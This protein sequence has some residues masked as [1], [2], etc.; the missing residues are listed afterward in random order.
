MSDVDQV[1]NDL[2]LFRR[3]YLDLLD[4]VSNAAER[5]QH[6]FGPN[7]VSDVYIRP[8]L[9]DGPFKSIEKI[10]RKL[11]E[12]GLEGPGA[13]L[14]LND[15]IG[16]TIVVQYPDQREVA[17]AELRAQL[18]KDIVVGEAEVH[19]NKRGYYAHHAI[20]SRLY[21]IHT[22]R[23]EVQVKTMLHNAWAQKMHDLTYKP[24]GSL[25]TRLEK[26]MIAGANMIESAEQQSQTIR[27]MIL[28]SW[29]VERDARRQAC[30]YVFEE[31]LRYNSDLWK[32]I[33][34]QTEVQMLHGDI[35][36]A[37]TWL[38]KEEPGS[39]RLTELLER[40]NACGKR[41]A[42][43]GWLFAGRLASIRPDENLVSSCILLTDRWLKALP[44][45]VRKGDIRSSEISAIPLMF[46]IMNNFDDAIR[47]ADRLLDMLAGSK[48]ESKALAVI[49]FNRAQFLVEREYHAP[50]KDAGDRAALRREIELV[51][52]DE[53]L[54]LN[55]DI[56]SSIQ[57]LRG[58]I[59]I[60][61]GDTK[62]EVRAGIGLCTDALA[63]A[64]EREKQVS[65]AYCEL[66]MRL[67]WRRYFALEAAEL[68]RQNVRPLSGSAGL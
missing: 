1:A 43:F 5:V 63:V 45:H 64:A 35:E 23:C 8:D 41:A 67:G 61:F 47:Y 42:R 50:T 13:L 20:C 6:K 14:E 46:Y 38:A 19:E 28:V 7:I 30:E 2:K 54:R 49:R 21:G 56:E 31:M 52:D 29:D 44:G 27:D 22:L 53:A 33:P 66:N 59:Q 24:G 32:D 18:G 12:R 68:A 3:N 15:V 16:L 17:V 37:I 4:R 60:T 26:L 9:G 36:A 11:Q 48:L 65:D 39:Q 62:E 58:L 55:E 57:D 34:E 25:D 10:A 40:V 51:F